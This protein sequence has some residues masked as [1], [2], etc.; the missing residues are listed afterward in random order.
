MATSN[1]SARSSLLRTIACRANA[2][3]AL[4]SGSSCGAGEV[5]VA[6]EWEE[7]AVGDSARPLAP[8]L[9]GRDVRPAWQLEAAKACA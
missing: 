5:A 6:L 7:D 1:A 2:A 9:G 8:I 4:A 3:A